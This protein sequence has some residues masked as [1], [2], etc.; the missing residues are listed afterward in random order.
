MQDFVIG[1]PSREMLV[2]VMSAT[3]SN[4]T[5]MTARV[6][7]ITRHLQMGRILLLV[8]ADCQEMFNRFILKA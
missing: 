4:Q 5:T 6:T 2:L 8:D 3:P 1:L 7:T